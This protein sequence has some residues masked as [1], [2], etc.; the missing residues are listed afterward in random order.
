M[1]TATLEEVKAELGRLAKI[2]AILEAPPTTLFTVPEADIELAAGE[3]Y[4]GIVLGADGL[5]DHHLILLPGEAEDV[6]SQGAKEWATA[7]GGELPTRQEQALLYANAKAQFREAWYWSAEERT[8]GSYAWF[9][10][11]V[12]GY[13]GHGHKGYEGRARAVRRFTA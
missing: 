13:Q 9:Q 11:F 8:D 12:N 4:I 6:T 2:V 10:S 7:A 3:R 1:S 5:I